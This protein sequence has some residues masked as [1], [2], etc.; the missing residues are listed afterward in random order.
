SVPAVG[1][2]QGR[3]AEGRSHSAGN[4]FADAT[5]ASPAMR[6]LGIAIVTRPAAPRA[7]AATNGRTRDFFMTPSNGT[8]RSAA[9]PSLFQAGTGAPLPKRE[10]IPHSMAVSRKAG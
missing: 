9:G 2:R 4:V 1:I 7:D 6:W 5:L 10:L 8:R 3:T